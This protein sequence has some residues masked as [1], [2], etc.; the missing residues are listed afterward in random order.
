MN[1][2]I[3]RNNLKID[4]MNAALKKILEDSVI[5]IDTTFMDD[6]YGN[7]DEAYTK[8]GLHITDTGYKVLKNE[9]EKTMRGIGL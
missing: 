9:I 8:D 1:G 6:K 2:R 4:A 7:L 5:W 3:D